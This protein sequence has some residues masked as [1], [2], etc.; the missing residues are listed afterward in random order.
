MC[1]SRRSIVGIPARCERGIVQWP[2]I[3]RSATSQ[4]TKVLVGHTGWM[5]QHVFDR[6]VAFHFLAARASFGRWWKDFCFRYVHHFLMAQPRTDPFLPQ[7][8]RFS[9]S[10]DYGRRLLEMDGGGG[11][12]W[13]CVALL[14]WF[15]G[16]RCVACCFV[17]CW[18]RQ[19]GKS[20]R[21][22]RTQRARKK[23]R[24]TSIEKERRK[25]KVEESSSRTLA[26][27][28]HIIIP[29]TRSKFHHVPQSSKCC[30][31]DSRPQEGCQRGDAAQG[32]LLPS[33]LVHCGLPHPSNFCLC[34]NVLSTEGRPH[35]IPTSGYILRKTQR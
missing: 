21:S 25:A 32:R 7:N 1:V 18:M 14:R 16:L 22:V 4:P 24:Q 12:W 34:G 6:S 29:H 13:G 27:V 11:A 3:C 28:L 2:T 8:Y 15:V 19:E 31:D 20:S 9:P 26:Q 33:P 17:L 5:P 23:R 30:N 10:V 35:K